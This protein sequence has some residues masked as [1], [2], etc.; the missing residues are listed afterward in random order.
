MKIKSFT[1]TGLLQNSIAQMEYDIH[2]KKES[3]EFNKM[4]TEI[5]AFIKTKGTF[6]LIDNSAKTKIPYRALSVDSTVVLCQKQTTPCSL[7]PLEIKGFYEG[8]ILNQEE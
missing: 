2:K 8:V 6:S 5:Q 7:L 1:G 3:P 4:F